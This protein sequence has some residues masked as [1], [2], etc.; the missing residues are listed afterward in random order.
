MARRGG[1]V[2]LYEEEAKLRRVRDNYLRLVAAA[3]AAGETV[4]TV[5]GSAD[6][7]TVAAAVVTAI[8]PYLP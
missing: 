5:D 4:L 8:T 1:G 2:E 3:Q 7:A 6:A